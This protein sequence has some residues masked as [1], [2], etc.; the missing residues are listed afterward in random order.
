SLVVVADVLVV[1]DDDVARHEDRE[2]ADVR[3]GD[4]RLDLRPHVGM[5]FEVPRPHLRTQPRDHPAASRHSFVP[6]AVSPLT[7]NRCENRKMSRTGATEMMVASART[8]REMVT[9]P[10]VVG[11]NSGTLDSSSAS[12]TWM[13]DLRPGTITKGKK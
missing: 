3:L 1:P 10:A 11:L 12:P 8:G 6:P 2:V 7:R 9:D 13:G 5:E 4:R